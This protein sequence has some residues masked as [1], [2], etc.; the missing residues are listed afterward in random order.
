MSRPKLSLPH[1][2]AKARLKSQII[3]H[4]VRIAEHK[5]KLSAKKTELAAM[6]PRKPGG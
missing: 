4:R 3:D 2:R 6:S 5:E 1:E